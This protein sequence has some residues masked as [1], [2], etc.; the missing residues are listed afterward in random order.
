MTIFPKPVLEYWHEAFAGDGS[1]TWTVSERLNP[2][3]SAM[4]LEGMDGSVRTVLRPE[5]IDRIGPHAAGATSI[6][7]IQGQLARGGVS[8]HDPDYLL[9]FPADSCIAPDRSMAARRL[10]IEDR[11]AFEAFQADASEQDR[12]DAFVEIDHW[13]VFGCFDGERLVSAASACPWDGAPVAD[14]GVL[15]LPDVRGRGFARAV[16][17][18]ISDFS[19]R[20]GYEPQYRCQLDK[21]A[22]VALAKSCSFALFGKWIVA[23]DM[24]DHTT[25]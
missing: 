17:L 1:S 21:F 2:K 9:Y 24:P 4:M 18:A 5:L 13:A 23:S 6:A 25:A 12:D 8:L 14:L 7:G 20:Q 19:R 22:S 3:R 11:T 15:T 16:V 10:T